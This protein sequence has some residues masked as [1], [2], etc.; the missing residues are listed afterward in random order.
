VLASLF[1]GTMSFSMVN[2]ATWSEV[3]FSFE[4]TFG[5]IAGSFVFAAAMGILGGFFPAMRAAFTSP[6]EAMRN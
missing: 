6:I 4:P 1:M 2:F 3:V 5:I